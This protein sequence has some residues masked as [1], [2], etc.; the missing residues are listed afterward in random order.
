MKIN[1]IV[2]DCNVFSPLADDTADI[3]GH[4][5]L[6]G[7][8]YTDKSKIVKEECL[9]LTELKSISAQSIS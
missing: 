2:S 3:A 6:S 8:T 4:E 1:M 7:V 5:Q 9:G